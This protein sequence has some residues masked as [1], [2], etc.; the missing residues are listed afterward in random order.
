MEEQRLEIA[1]ELKQQPT[2][3]DINE[4]VL[5]VMRKLYWLCNLEPDKIKPVLRELD[6]ITVFTKKRG[7]GT[8]TRNVLQKMD[9][10]WRIGTVQGK[11]NPHRAD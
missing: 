5:A 11:L 8:G 6:H 3:K 9:V 4:T 7:T 2:E 1:Q 10:H